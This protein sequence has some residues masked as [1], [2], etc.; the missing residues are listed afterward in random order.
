MMILLSELLAEYPEC[1]FIIHGNEQIAM[2]W[3]ETSYNVI[4]VW[5]IQNIPQNKEGI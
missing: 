3:E 5:K 4:E 1:Q 2:E